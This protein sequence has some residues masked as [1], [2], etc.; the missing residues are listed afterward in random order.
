M[1]WEDENNEMSHEEIEKTPIYQK[2]HEIMEMVQVINALVQGDEPTDTD[3]EDIEREMTLHCMNDMVES[4]LIVM[5]KIGAHYGPSLYSIRMEAAT[6]IRMHAMR[7]R[8]NINGLEMG[9]YKETEYFNTLRKSVDEFQILFAEWVATFD[10]WDYIIDRWGLFNPPGVKY[11]DKD[12]DDDL[13]FNNP[14]KDL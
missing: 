10:P 11:D 6:L 2:A 8:L 14:L 7:V 1:N 3:E 12:P 5:V 4:S 9:G 13:P